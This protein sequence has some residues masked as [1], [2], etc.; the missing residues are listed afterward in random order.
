[1]KKIRKIRILDLCSTA[2]LSPCN[3]R[4]INFLDGDDDVFW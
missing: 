4:L 3:G 2:P 1:M